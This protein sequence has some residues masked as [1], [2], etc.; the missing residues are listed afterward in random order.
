MC[1][2][3]SVSEFIMFRSVSNAD[4]SDDQWAVQV[5][6]GATPVKCLIDTGA[7][8]SGAAGSL[9]VRTLGQ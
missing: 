5:L 7:D 9:V 4:R 2:T 3:K 6:I 1:H 8:A